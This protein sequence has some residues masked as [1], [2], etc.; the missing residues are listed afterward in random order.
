MA[1]FE[2]MYQQGIA[3]SKKQNKKNLLFSVL[4]GLATNSAVPLLQHFQNKSIQNSKAEFGKQFLESPE[5]QDINP[6]YQNLAARYAGQGDIEN[7]YQMI[8]AGAKAKEEADL[9]SAAEQFQKTGDSRAYEQVLLKQNPTAWATLQKST[10][11]EKNQVLNDLNQQLGVQKQEAKAQEVPQVTETEKLIKSVVAQN[12]SAADLSLD[13]DEFAARF[14]LTKPQAM[15]VKSGLEKAQS[16]LGVRAT[17]PGFLRGLGERFGLLDKPTQLSPKAGLEA[18]QSAL[19]SPEAL[20]QNEEAKAEQERIRRMQ[21]Q[22]QAEQAQNVFLS[23][24]RSTAPVSKAQK[25][26]AATVRVQR[27]DGAIGRIPAKNLQAFLKANK[28]AKVLGE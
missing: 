21:E 15:Q 18:A 20:A 16:D 13:L 11:A 10:R 19:I 17:E 26:A 4:S 27:P 1:D 22:V 9:K 23:K 3:D 6:N 14:G 12:P 7:T 24:P 8:K 25:E 2:A 28:G 5:F